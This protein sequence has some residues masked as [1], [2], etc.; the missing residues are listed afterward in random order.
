MS[1]KVSLTSAFIN[2]RIIYLGSAGM[3]LVIAGVDKVSW[4]V[5]TKNIVRI[6]ADIQNNY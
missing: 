3:F 1:Y 6:N 2:F 5:M 4:E